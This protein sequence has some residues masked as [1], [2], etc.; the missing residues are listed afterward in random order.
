ME[1]VT[2]KES[3]AKNP[4]VRII[5]FSRKASP[6]PHRRNQKAIATLPRLFWATMSV[7]ASKR[8]RANGVVG[9]SSCKSAAT[10]CVRPLIDL[11]GCVSRFR[12]DLLRGP[13]ENAPLSVD[14]TSEYVVASPLSLRIASPRGLT[15]ADVTFDVCQPWSHPYRLVRVAGRVPMEYDALESSERKAALDRLIGDM[16]VSATLD[17][18]AT[19]STGAGVRLSPLARVSSDPLPGHCVLIEIPVPAG[20][21][22]HPGA[23]ISLTV[24]VAGSP[25][26]LRIP[27]A[28]HIHCAT[29]NHSMADAGA[30]WQAAFLG[31]VAALEAALA[32]RGSTEEKDAAVRSRWER[33]PPLTG[34]IASDS[35]HRALPLLIVLL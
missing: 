16:R 22:M 35:K 14:A 26:T 7:A 19:L 32:A 15:A 4:A 27:A 9:A 31:D 20:I 1:E 11:S 30:V 25:I 29:C 6:P 13:L 10:P 17:N 12:I 33:T 8:A 34:F 18:A 2:V 3:S 23:A 21:T 28:G 24:S 5:L